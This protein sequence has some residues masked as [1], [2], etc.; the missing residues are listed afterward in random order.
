M[1]E[2][3]YSKIDGMGSIFHKIYDLLENNSSH[4]IKYLGATEV[5]PSAFNKIALSFLHDIVYIAG[6][7]KFSEII[8]IYKFLLPHEKSFDKVKT[9]L[10]ILCSYDAAWHTQSTDGKKIYHTTSNKPFLSYRGNFDLNLAVAN[11][12]HYHFKYNKGRISV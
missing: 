9:L 7:L 10:S 5:S 2:R 1:T 8:D 6:P 4:S 12:R 3:S 11:F